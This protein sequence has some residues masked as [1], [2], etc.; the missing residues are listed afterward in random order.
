MRVLIVD[1]DEDSRLLQYAAINGSGYTVETAINGSDALEKARLF[2]PHIIISDILMPEMDGYELCRAIKTDPELHQIPF[3]FYT[4]TYLEPKNK[5]L[6]LSLGATRFVVKPVEPTEFL[7]VIR[8]V[9][10]EVRQRTVPIPE[11]PSI[12]SQEFNAR[13]GQ[14]LGRKLDEKMAELEEQSRILERVEHDYQQLIRSIDDIVF[15]TDARLCWTL[16]NPAWTAL[17]GHSVEETLTKPV[18]DFVHEDDRAICL[19]YMD[20]LIRG[21]EEGETREYRFLDSEG[22]VRWF[23]VRAKRYGGDRPAGLTGVLRDITKQQQALIALKESEEKYRR[24]V[25]LAN[26]A[27]LVIDSESGTLLDANMRLQ[28]IVGLSREELI[29]RHFTSLYPER[30]HGMHE[31]L[32]KE[33]VSKGGLISDELWLKRSDGQLVPVEIS[34][35]VLDWLD[36][37]AVQQIMRNVSER[38]VR[39]KE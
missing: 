6:A 30:M 1:D 8:E 12:D 33:M 17:L 3:V 15:R 4:A 9:L 29:G 25:N 39:E 22:G 36:K 13:H 34:A 23:G 26:D 14:Q 7:R 10:N 19:D 2:R 38:L 16:L 21:A 37:R 32:F 5:E 11:A 20:G 18:V 28:E 24:L 31:T 35:S 27:I